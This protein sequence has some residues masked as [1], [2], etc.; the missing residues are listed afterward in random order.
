MVDEVSDTNEFG[1]RY[2]YRLVRGL[3][4]DGE[5]LGRWSARAADPKL[6]E[7]FPYMAIQ[8]MYWNARAEKLKLAA[9]PSGEWAQKAVMQL[10]RAKKHNDEVEQQRATYMEETYGEETPEHCDSGH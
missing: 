2:V 8:N 3:K 7:R 10:R 6:I 5:E 9:W 4:P 1:T